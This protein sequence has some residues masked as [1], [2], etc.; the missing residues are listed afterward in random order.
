M[1]KWNDGARMPLLWKKSDV[2]QQNQ[3]IKKTY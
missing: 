1:G 3:Q 2:R